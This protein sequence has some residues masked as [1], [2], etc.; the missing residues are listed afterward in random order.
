[1]MATAMAV[2]PPHLF[3]PPDKY[4]GAVVEDLQLPPAFT[5]YAGEA[6][7]RAIALAYERD[8]SH[9]PV[10]DRRR[11]PLGYIEVATLKAQWEAGNADA[12]DTVLNYM[13]KFKRT[14]SQ[15]YTLITPATALSELEGFLQHN[16]FAIVTDPSRK[17]VIALATPQ[18]LDTF[19]SRRGS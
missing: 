19:F 3:A 11:R 7:S 17:F 4:R 14:A 2:A 12:N 10:L 16:I 9:I 5:V 18:D 6:I 8:F 15:P 13:T 1:M